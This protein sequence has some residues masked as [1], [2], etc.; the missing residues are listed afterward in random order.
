MSG[1]SMAVYPTPSTTN[2][3]RRLTLDPNVFDFVVNDLSQYDHLR[4]S[5][6]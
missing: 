4:D 2:N 1:A 5:P 6:N 3:D